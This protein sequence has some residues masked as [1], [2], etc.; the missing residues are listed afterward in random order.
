[1]AKLAPP[2]NTLQ[3]LPA[4]VQP[5]VSEN[6]QRSASPQDIQNVQNAQ[7]SERVPSSGTI[8]NGAPLAIDLSN[9]M[10][11]SDLDILLIV[12]A[13]LVVLVAAG[14]WLWKSF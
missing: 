13:V 5:A 12:V 8:Q 11:S 7:S 10:H 4:E 6:V 14:T 3:P 9:S 2:Q 1:M